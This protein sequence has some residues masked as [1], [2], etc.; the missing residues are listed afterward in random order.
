[1][2]LPARSKKQVDI[3]DF[4]AI[5]IRRIWYGLKQE[6]VAFWFLC[7]CIFFEYVRPQTLYPAIDIL[8]YGQILLLLACITAI[9][10][11]DIKWVKNP[12][13]V[14]FVIFYIVVVLASV[15]AFKPSLSFSKIDI[16]TNWVIL[17][18]LI[19]T[20]LD[21]EKKYIGFLLVY[22]LV[23]FK[24]SQF[25][26]RS[27]IYKG[28]SSFGVSGSPGWFKDSGDLGI[29]M[30]L[31]TPL[32]TAFILALKE[33]WGKYKT[34]L[35]WALPVTALVTIVATTSRGAQ[36]GIAAT[37]LWFL[38]K[39]PRGIKV[40]AGIVVAGVLFYWL[41]PE[42]MI[43]EFES[44]G[45]DRTSQGRLALWEAGLDIF[46]DHPVLGVGYYNWQS[47]CNF[48]NPEGVGNKDYCLVAHNTYVTAAAEIGLVGI[49]LYLS[50]IIFILILNART[51][52][53]ARMNNN[54]FIW[55]I[56]HGLDGGVVG[57]TVA[58]VFYTVLFYPMLYIQLAMTVALN[59]LSKKDMDTS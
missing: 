43:E 9:T 17:Y 7:G 39:N 35:F 50:I 27:F 1:M 22:F 57:F 41:L 14:L 56:A 12:G 59:A 3:T 25:G 52:A 16:I 33:Y 20:V 58:T 23:N 47:Y 15:L 49:L 4:Y 31:F 45:E 38:I 6:S 55:F 19:I 21:S 29:Q 53:N 5:R 26:F 37:G 30:I 34:M 24:M 48:V 36:L 28:Y 10:N 46:L 44:A 8:P 13:N 51:R 18:F 11:R 40:I 54:R 2:K 42:K 32:V